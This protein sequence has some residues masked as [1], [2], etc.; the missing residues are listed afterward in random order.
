M[1]KIKLLFVALLLCT[2]GF[3]Q[4]AI[5]GVISIKSPDIHNDNTVTFRFKAPQAKKV[6]ITGDF[7]PT[8][9]IDT[10]YGKFDVAGVAPLTMNKDSIWEFTTPAPLAS[11][12]Y[13]YN[14]IVDGMR[15]L[16]PSNVYMNRD[17][18]VVTNIFII[19]GQPGDLYK[20]NKVAHGSVAKTWYDSPTLGMKRRMTVYTPA[21]YED[22]LKQR[23]PVLYLLHGMGGDE[24]AWMALGR[25]SQVL[26]NLIAQGKIKPMIVVMTNG[27]AVQEAAPGESSLG[28]QQPSSQLP[29]T[30]EGSFEKSFPDIVKYI[31]NHYRT[32]S[33]KESRAIC[34]LS[35]GG[36]HSKFISAEYP[37]MFNYIGLFSAA[38]TPQK[39]VTAE[40]YQNQDAKLKT[41]FAKKPKLYWIGIGNADFLYK[42]NADYRKY[43]DDHHYPYTYVETTEGHI[44]KNWRIYL[45]QFSQKL[46]K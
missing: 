13:G 23:Y 35:M 10:P 40:I 32:I 9:K 18:T 37:D 29:K 27:N 19:G 42:D 39:N 12:L 4:Q 41:L 15:M 1:K 28:F 11:E 43:L 30:M 44:W 26:D 8:R 34:G 31:D 5:W 14:F 17:A 36:F 24:E 16:D 20:V 45:T 21:G 7:L 6:E 22:N 38:I 2:S 33:K 3:A 46:F 25:A